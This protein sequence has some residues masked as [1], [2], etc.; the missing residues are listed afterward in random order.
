MLLLYNLGVNTYMIFL[1]GLSSKKAVELEGG[2]M[3]NY[4]GVGAAQWL[5]S[6]PLFFLPIILFFLFKLVLD[7]NEAF[8]AL[9]GIGLIGIL[10]QPVLINYFSKAY[11]KRK[12]QLIKNYKNS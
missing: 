9:G 6:L 8:A 5:I 4:Q 2:A 3:F 12:H 10:L 7:F 1:F 11:L